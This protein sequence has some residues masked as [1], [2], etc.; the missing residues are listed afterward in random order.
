MT[1]ITKKHLHRRTFLRGAGVAIALPLLDSMLPA[2]AQSSAKRPLRF[3]AVY[4]P[5]G[6]YPQL[7]H[8]TKV[9]TGFDFASS[10]RT[11]TTSS[12]SAR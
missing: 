9:G 1:F 2:F 5:N 8:P 4:M 11:A 7:W 10:S 12:R 3:G 6:V